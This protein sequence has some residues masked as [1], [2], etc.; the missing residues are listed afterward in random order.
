MLARFA[1]GGAAITRHRFGKGSATV[2]GIWSG[3]TYSAKVRRSDFSMREDFDAEVRALIAAT[4]LDRGV[5]QPARPSEPLVE[6]V[7]L[8]K[9]GRRSVALINWA[10]QR[11]VGA[12]GKG[13][14]QSA[15]NLRVDLAGLGA[16]KSVRSLTHG[17]LALEG[18][19]VRLPNLGAWLVGQMGPA[20]KQFHNRKAREKRQEDAAEIA[21][22]GSIEKLLALVNDPEALRRDDEDFRS[23]QRAYHQITREIDALGDA[24]RQVGQRLAADRELDQMKRHVREA[25]GSGEG[26]AR[27]LS[28]FASCGASCTG[29]GAGCGGLGRASDDAGAPDDG[30]LAVCT[31][32]GRRRAVV[33]R[34][35]SG[36]GWLLFGHAMAVELAH[37]RVL[38][39]H[40]VADMAGASP[41][42]W[43]V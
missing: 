24:A 41:S 25:S 15:E 13:E 7:A 37:R 3:L 30:P 23:A 22:Q 16:V 34:C 20:F 9:D 4:A 29:A 39:V 10:Y 36:F 26:R 35:G 32:V 31:M 1:D 43:A 38:L 2:A 11:P 40:A 17:P 18:G 28:A 21:K 8:D 33:G 14:L 19:A 12:P 5:R 42:G 27:Q 6:A